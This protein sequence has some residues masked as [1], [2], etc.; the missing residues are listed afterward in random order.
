MNSQIAGFARVVVLSFV[1]SGILALLWRSNLPAQDRKEGTELEKL[2]GNFEYRLTTGSKYRL[3][4][5][6]FEEDRSL[7]DQVRI[8]LCAAAAGDLNGD[9][10]GDAVAILTSNYGGSGSFYELTALVNQ[11]AAMEQ[12]N[13]VELGDRVEI[14]GLKVEAGAVVVDML[15]HGPDDPMCCPTMKTTR[16]FRLKDGLLTEIRREGVSAPGGPHPEATRGPRHD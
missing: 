4:N 16:R 7:D 6:L 14:K 15:A 12:A 5:G 11:G 13:S 10:L 1:A 8:R 9:G 3:T 2:A